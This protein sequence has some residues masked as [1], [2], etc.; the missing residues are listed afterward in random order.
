LNPAS[1][2]DKIIRGADGLSVAKKQV[3]YPTFVGS[4]AVINLKA[5]KA[6]P[7]GVARPRSRK[8]GPAMLIIPDYDAE[9]LAA[10]HHRPRR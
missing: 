5:A 3:A 4:C 1:A 10:P 2:S 7:A 8:G 9:D 6:V